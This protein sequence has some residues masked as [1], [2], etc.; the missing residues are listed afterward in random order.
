MFCKKCGTQLGQDDRFCPGCGAPTAEAPAA[1]T[2]PAPGNPLLAQRSNP[3]FLAAVICESAMAVFTLINLFVVLSSFGMVGSYMSVMGVD[4]DVARM[5]S[6]MIDTMSIFVTVA[7]LGSL[8][9]MAVILTGLW[10]TYASG[11]SRGKPSTL[12]RGLKLVRGGVLAEMV[13]MIV[14]LS[15]MALGC[16]LLISVGGMMNA[17]YDSYMYYPSDYA[18]GKAAAGLLT[19]MGLVILLFVAVLGVLMVIFYV[20]ARR[21]VGFALDTAQTGKV[22]G[23]PSMYMAVMCFIL[24]GFSLLSLFLGS[25][26]V[27]SVIS[28]LVGAAS[29]ILFGIVALQYRSKA[30]AQLTA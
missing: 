24:G 17:S 20:K 22:T 9:I 16:L 23:L 21:T 1:Y 26:H 13:Y 30:A 28:T 11:L 5:T 3:L 10:M 27:L 7:V 18:E 25:A 15:L 12:V 19:T 2:A 29:Y 8:A 14:G 4:R 6:S